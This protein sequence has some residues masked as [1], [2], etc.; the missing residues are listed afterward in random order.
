MNREEV[1]KRMILLG[2]VGSQAYRINTATSDIDLKGIAV[3]KKRHYLGFETFEQKDQGW[4]SEPG[5]IE[6][7]NNSA[8]V[9]VY[10]LKKYLHLAAL[11]NPNILELMWLDAED[12]LLLTNVGKKLIYYRKEM[13]CTK[14]K[15]SFSG[16]AFAQLK[17]IESHRKWLLNPPTKKP[18]LADFGLSEEYKPLTKD[19]INAFLEF[20]YLSVQDCIEFMQPAEELYELLIARIDYKG[21]FKQHPLPEE[22]LSNVQ[23][24]TRASNDFIRLLH[25]SQAYRTALR[26]YDN[27]QSWKKNRNVTRAESERQVGYDVKHAAHLIRLLRMGIEI[28]TTGEVIVNREKAGDAPQLKAIRNCEYSDE[29]LKTLADELFAEIEAVYPKSVLPKYVDRARI[30]DICVELV[31]MQG[32]K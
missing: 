22:L 28:L 31:E 19:Q 5:N 3:A 9:C 17:K 11:N 2:I 16:Y 15:H 13:L 4:H 6:A 1:E 32:W 30:N 27:Y 10:E 26:E 20:L 29:Q 23:H 25:I 18:E 14:V 12:Y 8:D 7:I 21:I 24:L